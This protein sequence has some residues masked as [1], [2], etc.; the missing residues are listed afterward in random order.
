MSTAHENGVSTVC[1]N[2]VSTLILTPWFEN[3]SSKFRNG[4]PTH[5]VVRGLSSFSLLRT[6]LIRHSGPDPLFLIFFPRLYCYATP[7]SQEPRAVRARRGSA[8]ALS[9]SPPWSPR[10]D[11]K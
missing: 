5:G 1:V 10:G 7:K 11:N 8:L 2:T 9:G 3:Y 4:M 6:S